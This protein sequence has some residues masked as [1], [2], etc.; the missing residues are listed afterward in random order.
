[1][2]SE[3]S[4][5]DIVHDAS[6]TRATGQCCLVARCTVLWNCLNHSALALFINI[7]HVHCLKNKEYKMTRGN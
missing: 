1:M 5:R 2:V 7:V 6:P 4:A 3:S